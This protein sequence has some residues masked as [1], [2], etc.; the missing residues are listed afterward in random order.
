MRYLALLL[1]LIGC[2]NSPRFKV[3]DC[4]RITTNNSSGDFYIRDIV[5][6]KYIV[7]LA[8]NTG[9]FP[10]YAARKHV[11]SFREINEHTDT[12]KIECSEVE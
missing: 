10:Q 9:G 11:F 4:I 1:L 2:G 5:N 12:K 7:S 8:L 6:D 3:G